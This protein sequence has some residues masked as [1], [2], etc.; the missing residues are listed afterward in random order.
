MTSSL[1]M[2]SPLVCQVQKNVLYEVQ[3]R[4]R[5]SHWSSYWSDWSPSMVVP[6]EIFRSPEINFTVGRLGGDG[7]R[8]VTVEWERPSPDQG[9]VK[10]ILEFDLPCRNCLSEMEALSKTVYNQTSY[11][12]ALSGAAYNVSLQAAN[13]AG[14]APVSFVWLPPE[15]ESGP[16][17]LNVSLSGQNFKAWWKAPV[18]AGMFCFE[19]QVLGDFP[20]ETPCNNTGLKTGKIYESSGVVKPNH[21]YRLAIHGLSQATSV[22]STLGFTHLFQRNSSFFPP[23]FSGRP[24]Q[25]QHDQANP[26]F[27][28][29]SVGAP[30]ALSSCP[31]V[32]KKFVICCRKD[33][34]SAQTTYYDASASEREFTIPEL[35]P[36]TAYLVGVWASTDKSGKDCEAHL[37]F[38]T[39]PAD[40]K[41][42]AL[43]LSFLTLGIFV[44]FLTAAGS[45]NFCRKRIQ[46]A[47]WPPLPGPDGTEAVKILSA[48]TPGQ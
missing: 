41:M 27:G 2:A 37:L 39:S 17:I 40:A 1:H 23:S 47:L 25:C 7:L 43:T 33:E 9:M 5:V 26:Q 19:S 32:L 20:L 48:V 30:G 12:V 21:C 42:T 24:H 15:Q 14:E 46:K 38:L 3:V 44:T 8:N 31:G 16:S 29:G 28:H 35:Q 13:K 6:A 11:Q 34:E 36:Q 45:F 18:D 22:W 4:Y 10:Y